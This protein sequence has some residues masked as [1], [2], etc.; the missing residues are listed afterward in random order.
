VASVFA[1][2]SNPPT[3]IT[4]ASVTT[5]FATVTVTPTPTRTQ[6]DI[7][8]ASV[9]NFATITVTTAPTAPSSLTTTQVEPANKSL[10]SY[11]VYLNIPWDYS[12]FSYIKYNSS[13]PIGSFDWCNRCNRCKYRGCSDCHCPCHYCNFSVQSE[14]SSTYHVDATGRSGT[15]ERRRLQTWCSSA[16]TPSHKRPRKYWTRNGIGFS[17]IRT[18]EISRQSGDLGIRKDSRGRVLTLTF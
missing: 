11:V 9:T 17:I 14:A 16:S 8:T 15:R 18:F 6:V 12:G 4:T 1:Y 5:D 7:T 13:N 2:E 10:W 3:I